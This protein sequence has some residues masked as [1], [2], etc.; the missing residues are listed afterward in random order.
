MSLHIGNYQVEP[1][2][3]KLECWKWENMIQSF[4]MTLI[5]GKEEGP[6]L[7]SAGIHGREE[8]LKFRTSSWSCPGK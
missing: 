6:V 3:K 8:V 5:C 4:P 2:E 1:G 7:I